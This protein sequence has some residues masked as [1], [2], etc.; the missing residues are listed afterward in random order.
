M[1]CYLHHPSVAAGLAYRNAADRVDDLLFLGLEDLDDQSRQSEE[2]PLDRYPPPADEDPP[3]AA[4]MSVGDLHLVD[5]LNRNVCTATSRTN[6]DW[7][8]MNCRDHRRG[9]RLYRYLLR[10]CGAVED[11]SAI[12]ASVAGVFCAALR[13]GLFK[14]PYIGAAV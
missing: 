11:I 6:D 8:L 4:V 14:L 2:Q 12:R 1:S 9:R 13:T 10:L 7:L 5:R 3:R